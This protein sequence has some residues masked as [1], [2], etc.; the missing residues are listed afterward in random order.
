MQ[1][2]SQKGTSI[3]CLSE[4]C[5]QVDI[6]DPSSIK[7]LFSSSDC[8]FQSVERPGPGC[9]P[10]FSSANRGEGFQSQPFWGERLSWVRAPNPNLL[11]Y[12]VHFIISFET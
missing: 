9:K 12:A 6:R 10:P 3:Q 1:R 4:R 8:C 2:V 5:E 7:E 11:S